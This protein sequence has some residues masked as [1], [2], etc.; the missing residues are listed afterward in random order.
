LLWTPRRAA[1]DRSTAAGP[2]RGGTERSRGF[3]LHLRPCELDT[4]AAGLDRRPCPRAGC[5][6]RRARTD[7]AGQHQDGRP[8]GLPLRTAGQPQ[9][10][11]DGGALRDRHPSGAAKEAARQGQGR[12]GGADRRALAA[13]AIAPPHLSQPGGGQRRNRRSDARTQRGAPAPPAAVG[14]SR[15]S[16]AQAAAGGRLRVRGE[17]IAAHLRG[18]GNHKHT[19]L[20][21]HM[22]SSHRRYAGWTPD[23]IRA[24]SVRRRRRCA[25]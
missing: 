15:R 23:R 21:E 2:R 1:A 20:C 11:G 25:S 8:Q 7:R 13:R 9:L 4:D 16:R 22:P 18:G 17:R 12:T 14:G 24:A 5:H 19:T 3:E 10:Y 6:R